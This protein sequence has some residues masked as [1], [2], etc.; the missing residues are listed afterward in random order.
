MDNE[1]VLCYFVY[2]KFSRMNLQLVGFLVAMIFFVYNVKMQSF[3][4]SGYSEIMLFLLFSKETSLTKS[5]QAPLSNTCAANN[6][7]QVSDL[8]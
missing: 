5:N 7:S 6:D 1:Y 3:Y 4:S 8:V 2:R